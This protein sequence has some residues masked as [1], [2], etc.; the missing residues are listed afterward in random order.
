MNNILVCPVCKSSLSFV[1]NALCCQNGHSFD[2]SSDGYVNLLLGSKPGDKTGDSRQMARARHSFLQIG[3]YSLLAKAVRDIVFSESPKTV[4]DICCGEGYYTSFLCDGVTSVY[5]FDLS[6]EMVRLAAKR[7]SSAF[8]FV[9]NMS[10]VPVE[11]SSV[12]CGVHMFA[13]LCASELARVLKPNGRLICVSPG[14]K[15][16]WGLKEALY[17]DPYQNDVSA[18]AVEGFTLEDVQRVDYSVTLASSSE[19]RQL[20]EMT[21]Y[22]KKTAKEAVDRLYKLDSLSTELDFIIHIYRRNCNE[23]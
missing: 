23:A 5:G 21:P 8:F 10:S 18:S 16:L 7:H 1:G 6:K 3:H 11:S 19:I 13:P 17:E 4:L 22:S 15:H 12:D 9:A 14:P 20:F 2:L